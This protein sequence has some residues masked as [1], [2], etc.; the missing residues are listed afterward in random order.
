MPP[1]PSSGSATS[2]LPA[3]P[4]WKLGLFLFSLP[5]ALRKKQYDSSQMCVFK[6]PR[7]VPSSVCSKSD[8]RQ[9]NQPRPGFS[10][11]GGVCAQGGRSLQ[12]LRGGRPNPQPVPNLPPNSGCPGDF[13]SSS[14]WKE[15]WR[16][17]EDKMST[18][19]IL[20]S[21]WVSESC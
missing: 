19:Y 9:G 1:L 15:G 13:R 10:P 14:R 6:I 2:S 7:G 16:V 11:G 21:W 4:A 18:E 3:S 17:E 8:G 12:L 5:P 20:T